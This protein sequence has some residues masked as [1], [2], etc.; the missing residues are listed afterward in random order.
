[1]KDALDAIAG[2]MNQLAFAVRGASGV[3]LTASVLVLAGALAAG[4]RSRIYDAVVLKTLGATRRRLL[5]ALVIEYTLLGLSTALFGLAA[6][7]LAGWF[8]LVKVMH[9]DAFVLALG[10]C[11]ERDRHRPAGDRRTRIAGYVARARSKAGRSLEV[12]LI[13]ERVTGAGPSDAAL[14]RPERQSILSQGR[15]PTCI[16]GTG[17]AT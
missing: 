2:A 9:L 11:P 14:S 4:Q 15:G 1:M 10:T 6:G 13:C 3:A 7:S 12:S 5:Y 17:C 8:V 16:G